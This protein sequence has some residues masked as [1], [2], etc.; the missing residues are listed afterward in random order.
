MNEERA[1]AAL[2]LP[3]N[4]PIAGNSHSFTNP[5]GRTGQ[6]I[7]IGTPTTLFLPLVQGRLVAARDQRVQDDPF[8]DR[9]PVDAG[10]R[11]DG[12]VAVGHDRVIDVVVHAGGE[13]VDEFQAGRV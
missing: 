12:D 1:G 9:G 8:G 6:G 11:G 2:T 5:V 7:P 13:E 3:S 4:T 10:R